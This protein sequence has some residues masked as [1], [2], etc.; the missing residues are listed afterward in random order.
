M[1]QISELTNLFKDNVILTTFI[2]MYGV[3]VVTYLFRNIP[4]NMIFVAPFFH[5]PWILAVCWTLNIEFQY[6]FFIGVFF[7]IIIGK[8][9]PALLFILLFSITGWLY[10]IITHDSYNG[11]AASAT[12][13]LYHAPLFCMGIVAFLLKIEKISTLEYFVCMILLLVI[14]LISLNYPKEVF[15]GFAASLFII[16]I[17]F[18]NKITNF[19]GKISYSLYLNHG[20]FVAY[21]DAVFRILFPQTMNIFANTFLIV[22]YYSII[23]FASWVFNW[24]FDSSRQSDW[25][26]Y[27]MHRKVSYYSVALTFTFLH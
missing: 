27:A 1:N 20:I 8:K 18:S 15:V 21:I 19:F 2:S 14:G 12:L 26:C 22:S 17:H 9:N 10:K 13:L 6:Y 23:F 7:S 24:S 25:L 16:Y 11:D 4:T 5:I 3:G